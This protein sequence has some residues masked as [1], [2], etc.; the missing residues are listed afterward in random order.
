[1]PFSI[2]DFHAHDSIPIRSPY[3]IAALKPLQLPDLGA[4]L[5]LL[6]RFLA[7]APGC[8]PVRRAHGDDDAFLADGA[9]AK[10][11][12]NGDAREGMSGKEGACDGV[13]GGEGWVF[14][15]VELYVLCRSIV[16]RLER[17]TDASR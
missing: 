1:M 2:P 9:F 8:L 13:Q 4:L 3:A 7:R 12:D 5:G 6:E 11:V 17:R 15:S 16:G 14:V 10:L